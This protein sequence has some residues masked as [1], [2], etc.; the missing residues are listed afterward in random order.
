V[1]IFDEVFKLFVMRYYDKM[2]KK[3]SRK[4]DKVVRT[5]LNDAI[6][7]FCDTMKEIKDTNVWEERKDF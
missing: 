6:E 2:P 5:K 3:E 7:F 4:K 1:I